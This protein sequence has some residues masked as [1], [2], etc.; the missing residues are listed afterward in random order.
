VQFGWLWR[1]TVLATQRFQTGSFESIP[2][3]RTGFP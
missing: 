2:I 3:S 1:K